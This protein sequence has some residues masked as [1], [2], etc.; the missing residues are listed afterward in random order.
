MVRDTMLRRKRKKVNES[1]SGSFLIKVVLSGAWHLLSL[2]CF[3]THCGVNRMSEELPIILGCH[4]WQVS[5]QPPPNFQ[6][7]HAT[8]WTATLSHSSFWSCAFPCFSRERH[9]FNRASILIQEK[10]DA[11]MEAICKHSCSNVPADLGLVSIHPHY[12][13]I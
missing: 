10:L 11:E 1:W 2:V 8:T 12:L 3:G 9:V 7:N 13:H 5:S 6:L 4:L